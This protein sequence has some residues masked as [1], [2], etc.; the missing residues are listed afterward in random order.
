MPG[1]EYFLG[2]GGHG[3]CDW[4]AFPRN[5]NQAHLPD[6]PTAPGELCPT[7]SN[8]RDS[9]CSAAL[10]KSLPR[11][12]RGARHSSGS[13]CHTHHCQ[14]TSSELWLSWVR[15]SRRG[16]G[17]GSSCA[18]AQS[19]GRSGKLGTDCSS[20]EKAEVTKGCS[21]QSSGNHGGYWKGHQQPG[22]GSG[23]T[24]PSAG[25]GTRGWRAPGC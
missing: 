18:A 6:P 1:T 20:Q 16:R 14:Q 23:P 4:N 19:P 21:R 8:S 10:I 24:V 2:E 5:L 9:R 22:R 12:A 11:V 3:T 17:G 7:F 15:K 13:T 25:V